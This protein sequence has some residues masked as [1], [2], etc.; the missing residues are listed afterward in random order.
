MQ[1]SQDTDPDGREVKK[2]GTYKWYGMSQK[3]FRKYRQDSTTY[4]QA[5]NAKQDVA[6]VDA[7]VLKALSRVVLDVGAF[8]VKTCLTV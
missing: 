6:I 4:W 8:L 2:T 7:S 5:A 1:F 3:M